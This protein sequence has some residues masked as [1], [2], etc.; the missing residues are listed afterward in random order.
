MKEHPGRREL[1]KRNLDL[2]RRIGRQIADLRAEL[3]LSQTALAGCAGLNQGYVWRIERGMAGASLESLQAI[4][5][6]LG[7]ELGIRLF[8]TGG[9]RLH[10]RFQAP[11]VEGLIRLLGTPWRAQPEVPIPAARGVIDVVL[12]RDSDQCVVVCECHSELRRLELVIRRAKEK[13][14]ALRSRDEQA[15]KVSTLLVLRSTEATRAVARAYQATLGAAF[16]AHVRDALEALRGD[17][18]W[19]GAAVIWA[20][21]EGGRAVI[22]EAPPRGVRFGRSR[23]AVNP[24]GALRS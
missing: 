1:A 2:R 13:T 24:D 19:P 4:S 23:G 20:R 14:E 16:P 11:M 10:D 5:A 21:L 8:P 9:P 18:P 3:N 6:C 15:S 12:R 17:R 22:L 7:C